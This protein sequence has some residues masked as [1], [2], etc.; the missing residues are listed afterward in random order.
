MLSNIRDRID[1]Y[2]MN[3][4][5]AWALWNLVILCFIVWL[6]VRTGNTFLQAL[7]AVVLA[8]AFL[9]GA[10]VIPI[11]AHNARL[12]ANLIQAARWIAI[13]LFTLAWTNTIPTH[14]L[15][16]LGVL[17]MLMWSMSASFWF[18]STPGIVTATGL[19]NLEKRAARNPAAYDPAEFDPEFED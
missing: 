13:I 9:A 16:H 17:A 10:I 1:A 5:T 15:V 3:I 14:P 6:I 7:A 19:R 18:I 2:R 8:T 4:G 11:V 12:A